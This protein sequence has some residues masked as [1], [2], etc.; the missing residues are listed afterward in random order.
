MKKLAQKYLT[1]SLK[2][3]ARYLKLKIYD[4]RQFFWEMTNSIKITF[5]AAD[6]T[7][8]VQFVL[9]KTKRIGDKLRLVLGYS[10]VW[11]QIVSDLKLTTNGVGVTNKK[12]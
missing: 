4:A 6:D 9:K 12:L 11:F 2:F 8:N 7:W 10:M 5:N 1:S 3:L